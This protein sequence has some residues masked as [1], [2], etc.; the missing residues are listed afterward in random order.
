M[1]IDWVRKLTS[2]KLWMAIC[3]FLT[4]LLTLRGMSADQ[5]EK[6]GGLIMMGA[7]VVAYIIGEGLDI[8]HLAGTRQ[9]RAD[10]ISELLKSRYANFDPKTTYAKLG[11]ALSDQQFGFETDRKTSGHIYKLIER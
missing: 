5:V 1:K 2:R 9:Q 10:R 8:H 11:R 3:G 7:S 4:G 6:I